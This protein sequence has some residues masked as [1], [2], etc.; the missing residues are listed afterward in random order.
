[1][2]SSSALTVGEELARLT[3]VSP[4]VL[5]RQSPFQFSWVWVAYN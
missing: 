4:K 3:F 5:D 2:T 1:M